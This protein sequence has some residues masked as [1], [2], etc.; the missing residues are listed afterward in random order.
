[1]ELLIE[2]QYL[3]NTLY[4]SL[5]AHTDKVILEKHENFVK[6]TYRSRAHILTSNGIDILSVPVLGSQKKIPITDIKIDYKQKW[7][8]RHW[9][10]I[11][12][13]YGKAPFF[14]H[15]AEL[16]NKVIFANYE[17]LFELNYQ[18]LTLCLKLLQLEI[19]MGFSE[20]YQNEPD[21]PI[22]DL[23][24][25]IHPK[26]SFTKQANFVYTPY[27]QVF[28]KGFVEGLSILDLLFSEG[29]NSGSIIRKQIRD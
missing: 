11:Q 13:A 2:L 24:S 6:Q 19:P 1:M 10:A 22:I 4:F 18:L 27:Q 20:K 15:Y 23:R 29:P 17:T 7:Q 12:S 28:G 21:L 26:Q 3:P 16:F 25:A 9:R 14:I 8:N 5:L